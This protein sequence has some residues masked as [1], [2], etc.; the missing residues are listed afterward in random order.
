M[1]KNCICSDYNGYLPWNSYQIYE[2]STEPCKSWEIWGF[3]AGQSSAQH[4]KES[5]RSCL[6]L[7]IF[8]NQKMLLNQKNAPD[9]KMNKKGEQKIKAPT[10]FGFWVLRADCAA[11][12]R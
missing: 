8:H 3:W 5:M 2:K 12:H 4:K 7:R 9:L 1:P 11:E 6:E 10:R